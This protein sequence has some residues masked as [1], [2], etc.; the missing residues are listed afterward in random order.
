[1][2]TAS[3]RLSNYFALRNV[4]SHIEIQKAL[5]H[6][7]LLSVGRVPGTETTWDITIWT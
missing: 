3:T 2:K 7:A 1:M 4:I 6:I 5:V